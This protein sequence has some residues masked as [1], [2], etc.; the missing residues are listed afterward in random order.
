MDEKQKNQGLVVNFGQVFLDRFSKYPIDD[1]K[2]I[3]D[4]VD[5]LSIHGFTNLPGRNKPSD[6]VDS[7]DYSYLEKVTFAQD[8]K[9]HHYHIDVSHLKH[10]SL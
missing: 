7:N 9:L 2:K 8:Y 1:I 4:F 3:Q 5:Y 10:Y 6:D